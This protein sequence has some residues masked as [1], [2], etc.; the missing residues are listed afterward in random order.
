MTSKPS[1]PPKSKAAAPGKPQD[2]GALQDIFEADHAQ[3]IAIDAYPVGDDRLVVAIEAI[4]KTRAASAIVAVTLG[5]Q[6]A[7]EVLHVSPRSA[8]DYLYD[9]AT[10]THIL[11]QGG[12]VLRLRAGIATFTP[13]DHALDRIAL[14]GTMLLA[15]GATKAFTIADDGTLAP[16]SIDTEFEIPAIAAT[17]TR[18]Y[19]GTRAGVLFAGD[20]KALQ[21]VARAEG[22]PLLHILALQPTPDGAVLIGARDSAA[23]F[24]NGALTRLALD[25]HATWTRAVCV[26]GTAELYAVEHWRSDEVMLHHRSGTTLPPIA[27]AKFKPIRSR[28]LPHA[29]T[30][31]HARAGTLVVSINEAIHVRSGHTWRTLKLAPSAKLLAYT[32]ATMKPFAGPELPQPTASPATTLDQPRRDGLYATRDESGWNIV[33]FVGER[34]VLTTS[35]MPEE[36]L[37]K[38]LKWLVPSKSDVPEPVELAGN[39]I[40]WGKAV[41]Y[42]GSWSSNQ[43]ELEMVSSINGYRATRR[44]DFYAEADLV[45]SKK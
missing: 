17:S 1:K 4:D 33:R 27:K 7:F 31:M 36:K 8:H 45:A 5:K 41:T 29:S 32:P 35:T 18:I 21:A 15:V 34:M 3:C 22:R 13:I 38:V 11:L 9:E 14:A 30:R 23:H 26:D 28:R 42:E 44:Y 39:R 20:R 16:I 12:G 24:A 43:L 10:D 40:K 2:L 37:K 6:P 19:A 25:P